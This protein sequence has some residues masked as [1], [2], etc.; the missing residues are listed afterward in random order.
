MILSDFLFIFKIVTIIYVA[1]S[2]YPL[3]YLSFRRYM[4]APFINRITAA[5][6]AFE[7][8]KYRRL[9]KVFRYF[10]LFIFIVVN[11]FLVQLFANLIPNSQNDEVSK[12]VILCSYLGIFLLPFV[13]WLRN[14]NGT[15]SI[16]TKDR[17]IKKYHDYILYL[18]GFSHDDYSTVNEIRLQNHL[19]YFSE[20]YFMSCLNR[21]VPACAVGMTK[22]YDPPQGATRVYLNDDI[23][24]DDVRELMEKA[25]KI[26]VLVDS[27]PSCIWEIIQSS[28]F[29][30]K[31]VFI[32]DNVKVYDDVRKKT[33]YPSF[34]PNVSN[35]E[36]F[37]IMYKN[38]KAM[39][40]RF[41]NS[42]N[43]YKELFIQTG[44]M[45]LVREI[46]E[47]TTSTMMTRTL[48]VYAV[49]V[50]FFIARLFIEV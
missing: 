1:L 28:S 3:L 46:Y 33:S 9:L 8:F 21:L 27:R 10:L 44:V 13:V 17:F 18:R 42:V 49:I 40:C 43:G 26:F 37:Y 4:E 31:T 19:F 48:Y 39:I 22:E 11:Y 5:E 35:K 24:Q 32:I 50:A 12:T 23:W 7:A 36:S 2:F 25:R 34:L 20:F 6:T 45:N 47:K 41:V 14:L 30:D 29:L 16:N 38:N 15:I